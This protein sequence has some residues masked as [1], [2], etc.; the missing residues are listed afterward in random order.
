MVLPWLSVLLFIQVETTF[1]IHVEGIRSVLV[2][3]GLVTLTFVVPAV[4]SSVAVVIIIAGSS[5]ARPEVNNTRD[6]ENEDVDGSMVRD[7]GEGASKDATVAGRSDKNPV[8]PSVVV[9][10]TSDLDTN[11]C[12]E[13][14]GGA[15]HGHNPFP[16]PPTPAP[17][18][19]ALLADSFTDDGAL[20]DSVG[21]TAV[22]LAASK[23][24][25]KCLR[26]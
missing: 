19:T 26:R 15:D 18:P 6:N 24:V 23:R 1:G 3:D 20:S 8:C 25:R 14:T 10:G 22:P 13:A 4:A 16:S 9:L 12:D 17:S 5:N 11:C 7:T 2:L 21:R